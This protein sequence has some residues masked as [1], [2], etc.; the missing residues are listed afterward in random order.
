M[1]VKKLGVCGG[2]LS[3]VGGVIYYCVIPFWVDSPRLFGTWGVFCVVNAIM[4]R[5]RLKQAFVSS[6]LVLMGAPVALLLFSWAWRVVSIA[7]DPFSFTG[8]TLWAFILVG[9]WTCRAKLRRAINQLRW[10]LN[11]HRFE[12][13]FRAAAALDLTTHGRARVVLTS[14]SEPP[15][16]TTATLQSILTCRAN[17]VAET[18]L[19]ALQSDEEKP[20]RQDRAILTHKLKAVQRQLSHLHGKKIPQQVV[21]LSVN[22]NKLVGNSL[23]ALRRFPVKDL[24]CNMLEVQFEDAGFI[25]NDRGGVTRDWMDS[26]GRA[27]STNILCDSKGKWSGLPQPVD[28]LAE[29]DAGM[30]L[31]AVGR[32]A[33]LCVLH[34]CHAPLELHSV[35]WQLLTSSSISLRQLWP[36]RDGFYEE[37]IAKLL[38][39]AEVNDPVAISEAAK[40]V[41]ADGDQLRFVCPDGGSE[42]VPNGSEKIVTPANA[43]EYVHTLAMRKL[44]RCNT[45]EVSALLGGFWELVPRDVMAAAGLQGWELAQLVQGDPRIDVDDWKAF[46]ECSGFN[47]T[48]SQVMWFWELMQQSDNAFRIQILQF[49]T[50]SGAVPVGGFGVL[51]PK[52]TIAKDPNPG[53]LPQAHVCANQLMLPE[54][55]TLDDLRK[56]LVLA[57]KHG[58]GFGF[59]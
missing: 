35:I 16:I 33:A 1:S 31:L 3:A 55:S 30:E 11:R 5:R 53:H 7:V 58:A 29:S 49:A 51:E 37:F 45:P 36:D 38:I 59:V 48:S 4:N 46:S 2:C 26:L 6:G 23:D 43:A 54:C 19:A 32:L 24:A 10:R 12:A 8:A 9:T 34:Q 40:I 57:C 13:D 50:G 15:E 14:P 47:D 41:A 52:F 18:E 39:A 21:Q 56:G 42:L 25:A 22:R 27:I 17:N 28:C 44:E 20:S